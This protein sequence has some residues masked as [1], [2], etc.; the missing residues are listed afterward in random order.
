[1]LKKFALRI[2]ALLGGILWRTFRRLK[3][4]RRKF[5]NREIKTRVRS[6]LGEVSHRKIR[7]LRLAFLPNAVRQCD[8]SS[9]GYAIEKIFMALDIKP[10]PF[11]PLFSFDIYLNWQDLTRDELDVKRYIELSYDHTKL[12]LNT[13][14]QFLNFQC[15]DIS[16]KKVGEVNK[17][18]FGYSLDIDP[19]SYSGSVVCK[20]DENATHDGVVLQCPL[21]PALVMSDK[22][23]SVEVKN[24]DRDEVVDF[25]VPYM[26]GNAGFFYEKRRPL[27]SRFSNTNS[28]V[29][30]RKLSD[31][32]SASE[33]FSIDSFCLEL[34]A[35]YGELDV[36]RDKIS[37]NIYIVDFAKTP[38]GPPKGL[39]K[40]DTKM[41]IQLMAIAFAQNILLK[42]T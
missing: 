2:D 25:R 34:G 39:N 9:G 42:P 18:V 17:K 7:K 13:H 32:F 31:E 20:S 16:K 12:Q 11:T 37:G 8:W 3:S 19:T 24:M 28:S 33:I 14:T 5:A 27:E 41:A 29:H 10:L 40:I 23:Y 1:V 35:D 6:A 36:L 38:F 4:G 15:S 30:L 22:V 21:D 26:R